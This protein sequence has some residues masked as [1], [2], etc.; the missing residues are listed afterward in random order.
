VFKNT[1]EG[2]RSV[3]KPRWRW[4]DD[5]D[6]DVKKVGVRGWEKIAKDRDVWKL[7]LKEAR[8]LLGL[9]NQWRESYSVDTKYVLTIVE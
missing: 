4:V 3:G 6:N 2:E 7:I 1:P 9:Y 5:V 8:V